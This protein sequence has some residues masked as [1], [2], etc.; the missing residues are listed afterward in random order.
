MPLAPCSVASAHSLE[1]S[2]ERIP[3]HTAKY[4]TAN[5]VCEH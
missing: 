3:D 5:S 4:A 1:G 2:A